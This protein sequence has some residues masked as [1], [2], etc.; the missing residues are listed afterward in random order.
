MPV[1]SAVD[2][3]AKER[4]HDG[5]GFAVTRSEGTYLYIND[6]YSMTIRAGFS[7]SFVN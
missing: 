1:V 5:K 7:L 2:F 4:D 3:R 6:T